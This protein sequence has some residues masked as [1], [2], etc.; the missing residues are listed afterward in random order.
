MSYEQPRGIISKTLYMAGQDVCTLIILTGIMLG[1]VLYYGASPI[2]EPTTIIL[3]LLLVLMCMIG[4]FLFRRILLNRKKAA[5]T[6]L[7]TIFRDWLPLS[8]VLIVFSNLPQYTGYIQPTV[9][10]DLLAEMELQIWSVQPTI[11]IEQFTHPILVDLMSISYSFHFPLSLGLAFGLYIFNHRVCFR[12]FA[13]AFIFC[14]ILGFTLYLMF[15][16]GPPRIF[17]DGL[18]QNASLPSFTGIYG[19][20]QAL[21]DTNHPIP[22]LS[23]FPSLHVAYSTLTLI[24][25]TKKSH[26]PAHVRR[27]AV[28][29][30]GTMA[31]SVWLSTIY[32][33]HH[34]TPDIAAGWALA[35]VSVIVGSYLTRLA[36][37]N[38]DRS[39][40]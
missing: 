38:H 35:G 11:W 22:R 33:R 32:L 16:T 24:F 29:L 18:Y 12:E 7:K 4:I 14:N 25:V 30:V 5:A 15:P 6:E 20:T 23:S 26:W 9:L 34:W 37:P 17:L 13:T 1:I 3:P 21:W 28:P 10:D 39:I 40:S 31:G 27:W 8:C 36:T 2:I 19:W